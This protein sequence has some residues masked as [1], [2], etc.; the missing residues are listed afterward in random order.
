[1]T[2]TCTKTEGSDYTL[3]YTSINQPINQSWCQLASAMAY[4]EPSSYSLPILGQ[5]KYALSSAIEIENVSRHIN[6]TTK[7]QKW[8][9]L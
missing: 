5:Q 3:Y 4:I 8:K 9:I 6:T 1:M 2:Y 7:A